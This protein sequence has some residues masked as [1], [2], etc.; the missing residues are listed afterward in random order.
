MPIGEFAYRTNLLSARFS[1][2]AAGLSLPG[3]ARVAARRGRRGL[4]EGCARALRL[5]APR[6]PPS[7]A[8][9]ASPTGRTRTRPRSTRS[10]PS[11]SA[12]MA[13]RRC[14]G[15]ATG[16][17]SGRR[18]F[19]LLIVF[20]AGISIG[21]P[22]AGTARRPGGARLSPG[23]AL[24]REPAA[25]SGSAARGVGP[26]RGARGCLGIA[27]RHRPWERRAHRAGSASSSSPPRAFAAHGGAGAFAA[28][29]LALAAVGVTPYLFLYIRSGTASDHQRGGPGHAGCAAGRHPPGPVSAPHS[30]RRSHRGA[31][32][33]QSRP[34]AR[35][36]SGFSSANYFQYFDWQ[37]A[38]SLADGRAPVITVAFLSLG[39]QWSRGRS[40]AATAPAWW[41]LLVL[42]LVTGL[43]LVAYMNFKPGFSLGVRSG[44]PKRTTTRCASGTTSS[45]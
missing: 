5:G 10:R 28:A 12:A 11:R 24:C 8:R 43:G 42:F 4:P 16:H 13:G 17:R 18:R 38:R 40:G 30:A 31:R 32:A 3:R 41:L 33:R 29:A 14:S 6:R 19:L 23:G 34:D 22:P 45:W 37:W 15:A 35:R 39:L 20:L 21:E 2:S 26:G 1:A 9:S 36:S 7:S 44:G 27:D 25:G